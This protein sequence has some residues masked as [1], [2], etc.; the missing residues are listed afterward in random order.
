MVTGIGIKI[1]RATIFQ[2]HSWLDVGKHSKLSHHHKPAIEKAVPLERI[3]GFFSQRFDDPYLNPNAELSF[4]DISSG[5]ADLPNEEVAEALA[6]WTGHSGERL[7]QTKTLEEGREDTRVW[8]LHGLAR[9]HI[10]WSDVGQSHLQST[11]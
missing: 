10:Q 5:L 7:L 2:N 3:I 1:F 8:Y 11:S 9:P 4:A 6:H